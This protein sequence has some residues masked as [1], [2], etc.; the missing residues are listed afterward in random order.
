L[1][2]QVA[3]RNFSIIAHIDHGKSTSPTASLRRTGACAP[4]K[5]PTR[6]WTAWTS[7]GRGASPSRRTRSG[8]EVR[9]LR[10][11]G[12]LLQS[13]STRR[14]TWTST[15][16]VSRSLSGMR[17]RYLVVDAS[18]GVEAQTLANTISP[19]TTIWRSSP[20]STRSNLPAPTCRRT[21]GPDETSSGSRRPGPSPPAPKKTG[22][23]KS[24]K[25][26]SAGP[27]PR[28]ASTT[29][30]SKPSSSTLV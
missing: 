30:R 6:S 29:S 24:W 15:Y 27:A 19:W 25:P 28:A 4:V 17:R 18:Q 5:W 3:H 21:K 1:H 11:P 13:H 8:W 10:T 9:G 14:D 12:I 23:R 2:G 22:T 20:S 16:E 26:S 7:S